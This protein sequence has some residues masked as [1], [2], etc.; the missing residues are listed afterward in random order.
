MLSWLW[1]DTVRSLKKRMVIAGTAGPTLP[2]ASCGIALLG[3]PAGGAVGFVSSGTATIRP[4]LP[5]LDRLFWRVG[6][7]RPFHRPITAAG[8]RVAIR[9]HTGV[10]LDLR[11]LRCI[12]LIK[13]CGVSGVPVLSSEGV[14]E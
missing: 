7:R 2:G 9:C 6:R 13:R 3:E 12:S 4:G 11:R 10:R 8:S 1:N 14:P 5:P